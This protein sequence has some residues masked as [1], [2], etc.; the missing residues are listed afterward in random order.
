MVVLLFTGGH[1]FI[2]LYILGSN[3]STSGEEGLA[4]DRTGQMLRK[5]AASSSSDDDCDP[6]HRDRRRS[7]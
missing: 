2:Q 5:V 4:D 3:A 7:L 6:S 1:Y